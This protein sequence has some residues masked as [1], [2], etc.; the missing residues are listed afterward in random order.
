MRERRFDAA[1]SSRRTAAAEM[2]DHVG[3]KPQADGSRS[4][5]SI[6]AGRGDRAG[7]GLAASVPNAAGKILVGQLWNFVVVLLAQLISIRLLSNRF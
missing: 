2:R 7:S 3:I 4:D 1:L 5:S 6:L